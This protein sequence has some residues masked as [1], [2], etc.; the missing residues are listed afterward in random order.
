MSIRPGARQARE[1]ARQKDGK[2]GHQQHD[3]ADG[4]DLYA[5]DT[6][7]MAC[8]D[9]TIEAAKQARL[10][11]V[12]SLRELRAMEQED[13]NSTVLDASTMKRLGRIAASMPRPLTEY[14]A[15]D[16][17]AAAAADIHED[18][19]NGKI[20]AKDRLP[21]SLLNRYVVAAQVRMGQLSSRHLTAVSLY[22][23][24]VKDE[25]SRAGRTLSRAEEDRIAE[26]VRQAIPAKNR[27]PA[28]YH[29]PVRVAASLDASGEG[30]GD[31]DMPAL[32]DTIADPT[33]PFAA[34]HS[35]D[36]EQVFDA[37]QRIEDGISTGIDTGDVSTREVRA[38]AWEAVKPLFEARFDHLEPVP[39][40]QVQG[41]SASTVVVASRH[42][43]AKGGAVQVARDYL[44]GKDDGRELFVPFGQGL[45]DGQ[46][47]S[48][49]EFVLYT[50]ETFGEDRANSIHKTAMTSSR[51]DAADSGLRVRAAMEKD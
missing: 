34:V 51:D 44:D 13:S 26:K 24:A 7:W 2:F 42:L 31:E 20:R 21:A 10:A 48:V 1:D 19:A 32:R 9:D 8:A 12:P 43:A 14:D 18:Y 29:R 5:D 28:G 16:L 23:R 40:V 50:E 6:D 37:I 38:R 3:R 4:I 47:E 46:K 27:P 25:S 17:V 33:D 35:D 41:N 30:F 11:T 36:P 49:V 45:T 22:S 15:E 39:D